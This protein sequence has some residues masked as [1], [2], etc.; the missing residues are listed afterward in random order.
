MYSSIGRVQ[1]VA[2]KICNRFLL[3]TKYMLQYL[4]LLVR[5]KN[6]SRTLTS[7]Y[8]LLQT[9][10]STSLYIKLIS[11]LLSFSHKMDG[12][13]NVFSKTFISVVER[14]KHTVVYPANFAVKARNDKMLHP[15][16]DNLSEI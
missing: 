14:K 7:I 15:T 16:I 13:L 6:K 3:Y 4:W 9:N 1:I 2:W 12:N 5:L 10:Q 11:Y 8:P